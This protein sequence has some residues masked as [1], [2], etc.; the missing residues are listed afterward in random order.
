MLFDVDFKDWR[1]AEKIA[2]YRCHSVPRVGEFF[3]D[4]L[5]L[6]TVNEVAHDVVK[7][8]NRIQP[9]VYVTLRKP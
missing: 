4:H 1:T 8:A 7:G 2:T 9:V 3:S 6:Y 5:D